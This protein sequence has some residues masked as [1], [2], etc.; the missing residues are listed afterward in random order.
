[1]IGTNNTGHRQDPPEETSAGIKAIIDQLHEKSPDTRVL[2]LAIF[3]RGEGPKD[4]LR[5][6]NDAINER[7]AKFAESSKVTFLDISEKF[8]DEDGTLPKKIMPDLLHPNQEGYEIWAKAVEPK[9]K[10]LLGES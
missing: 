6:L 3:P 2:L 7:I 8:L 5:K 1:M 9:L 4:E 10:E